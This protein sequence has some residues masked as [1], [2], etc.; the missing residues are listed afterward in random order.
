MMSPVEQWI[1]EKTGLND[2][3]SAE[4][5]RA[6]QETQ[7]QKQI[8][9]ATNN[10]SFY[11][12]KL[13]P[14]SRL[15][16]LPFTHPSE[17]VAQPQAFL[18]IP[19]HQVARVVTLSNSGTTP[20]RKRIFYSTNDLSNT[21]DFF[22]AGMKTMIQ[23]G[24]HACI[25][26]SNRTENSL[27]SL[28][29]QSLLRINVSADIPGTLRSADEALNAV[30][31]ADC[32]V[33]MPSEILYL[34]CLDKKLRP[35]SV[36][37][38]ADIAPQAVI[39]RIKE[40]WQCDVFTHYGHTEFGYGCAVDCNCHDGLHIRHADLIIEI[41][42]PE[43]MQP[44]L[45]GQKGE[46]VVTTLSNEA[47]PLI[48]YRTGQ[49]SH[50]INAPCKCGS[51]LP[52]LGKIEGRYQDFF[53][54]N[55]LSSLNIHELDEIIFSNHLVRSYFASL[56]QDE[57]SSVLMLDIESEKPVDISVLMNYIPGE[58]QVKINY[59][60]ADPFARRIK[61]RVFVN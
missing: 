39:D 46:V 21:I 60:N 59:T 35:K 55:N 38:A 61:R 6:W 25:L 43:T 23:S 53:P 36:L 8:Q 3:L 2:N 42:K 30:Q 28:L 41:I 52:R 7:L 11:R 14:Y 44:A 20:L 15:T 9:Y 19:Q 10:S 34:S 58:I 51:S 27:A 48:R 26:L 12:E 18:C 22:A 32:I 45:D 1:A 17:L 13:K 57:S 50:L 47:M 4:S 31:D 40:N 24:N 33:G 49:I 56:R 5:L 29:R 37:L 16:E 54:V